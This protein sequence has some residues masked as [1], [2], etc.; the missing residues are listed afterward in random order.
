[1]STVL[2][3]DSS[4]QS[5][6]AVLVDTGTGEV[7]AQATAAHPDGTSVDP[8][9][10]VAALRSCLSSLDIPGRPRN[11]RPC[12]IGIAGQQ[13]GMVALDS[14]GRP[15]TDAL[16]WNDTRSAPDSTRLLEDLGPD[17]WLERTGLI[18]GPSFTI[19]KLAWLARCLPDRAA[20]VARVLLPH[21]F[22]GF[23][24][25]G[26]AAT[27]RSEASGTGYF[28]PT[29]NSYDTELLLRYFGAVPE[30]PRVCAPDGVAG[31]VTGAWAE[32]GIA[33]LP[34]SAGMGDNAAA[35]LGLGTGDG[36]V[37]VSVGTSGT[38]FAS[39]PHPVRDEQGVV[40]GFADAKGGYLPL[41]ATLNASRVMAAMAGA[42]GVDL[43]E[44]SRL[45]DSAAP[46]AG[47]LTLLPYLDGER[48]PNLPD[49]AGTLTGITR[50]NLLPENLARAAVLSVLNSLR[51]GIEAVRTA[52]V[53]VDSVQ[54]IGGGAKSPALRRAAAD[55]F[56]VAVT[57]PRAA[58]YVAL[59]AAR[60]AAW[61]ATG[62]LPGFSV[63]VEAALTPAGDAGIAA[64]R[65]AYVAERVRLYGL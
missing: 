25:T 37:V 35:G 57:V 43:H 12:A 8:R 27:D 36:Q 34:V 30:L 48:T 21:D 9:A 63:D 32:F 60:Q 40:A 10:W 52:G 44:L 24:L 38:V 6:K 19:T 1:M 58:E 13:H 47:G 16:L 64:Y 14:A 39:S 53:T 46:D 22:L 41:I 31:T 2:G 29:T 42:L 28:N 17:V 20:A 49:A 4:T 59:G 7:L 15:V 18:P 51:D 23:T 61:A 3:I 55:A 54:L 11:E 65:A 26:S 45:A 33:G 50:A 56:G 5:C 62:A